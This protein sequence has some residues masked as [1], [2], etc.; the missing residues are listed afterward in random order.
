MFRYKAP[1]AYHTPFFKMKQIIT[2][3][4]NDNVTEIIFLKKQ[5]WGT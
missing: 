2:R 1:W 3:L 5:K 4:S